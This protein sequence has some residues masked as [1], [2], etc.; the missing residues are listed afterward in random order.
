MKMMWFIYAL[1][2]M[3]SFTVMILSFNKI[4]LL[5]MSS[6]TTIMYYSI[7]AALLVFVYVISTK[8]P[9]S[10]T[11]YMLIFL[12]IA[13][14]FGTIGNIFLLKSMQISPNP[15]YPVAIAG[16]QILLITVA[17]VFLFKSEITLVKGI[18][19]LFALI[20]IVLLGWK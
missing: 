8:I 3:V 9:L 20:G 1:I 12:I 17:S 10:M 19:I 11:K 6:E 15:G 4:G 5:G 2:A 13:V 18:G 7:F 16:L 14:V